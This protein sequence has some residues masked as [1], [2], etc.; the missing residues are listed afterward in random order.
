MVRPEGAQ[1]ATVIAGGA[2]GSGAWGEQVWLCSAGGI[3]ALSSSED[4]QCSG[5]P[6]S[7]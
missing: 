3:T 2:G 4:G 1:V 7:G 5:E 6:L